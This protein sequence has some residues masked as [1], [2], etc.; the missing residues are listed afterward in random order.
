MSEEIPTA[1]A[2]SA[3]ARAKTWCTRSAEVTELRRKL[4]P[5]LFNRFPLRNIY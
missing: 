5:L 2:E 3:P 1:G 4:N